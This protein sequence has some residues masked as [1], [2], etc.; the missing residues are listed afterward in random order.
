MKSVKK[1]L[2]VLLAVA[3]LAGIFP[4]GVM[5]V[6]ETDPAPVP[7]ITE[8]GAYIGDD[9]VMAVPVEQG[10]EDNAE[11]MSL[12]PL[13][14]RRYDLN[15]TG[16]LEEEL[17]NAS[18]QTLIA[19]LTPGYDPEQTAETDPSKYVVWAKWYYY[20]EDGNWV[21]PNDDYKLLGETVDLSSG[22]QNRD[23]YTIELI[24]G[25]CDQLNPDNVR[26]QVDVY[27]GGMDEMLS[28][29]ATTLDGKAITIYEDETYYQD[30][31]YS[32]DN[33]AYYQV[34]AK[35][36]GYPQGQIKVS[37]GFKSAA[38]EARGFDVAVYEG[39]YQTAE[40][41]PAEGSAKNVTEKIWM[42][43]TTDAEGYQ[44][45][46]SYRNMP[47]FT[48]VLTG[49]DNIKYVLP[50]GV[51]VYPDG[52][53]V[54]CNDLYKK[55]TT[56]SYDYVEWN[57]VYNYENSVE[58]NDITLRAGNSLTGTYYVRLYVNDP[59]GSYDDQIASVQAVYVGKLTQAQVD[60]KTPGGE[61]DVKAYLIRSKNYS[62]DGY[63]QGYLDGGYAVD[64]SQY[65]SGTVFTILDR[66]GEIHYVG[67]RLVGVRPSV[68]VTEQVQ[69]PLSDDIYFRMLGPNDENIRSYTMPYENDSYYYNGYQTVFLLNNGGPVT[70]E[71]IT[72]TFFEG[73]GVNMFSNGTPGNTS[74]AGAAQVSGE[75]QVNFLS[76]QGIRY[77]ATAENK[78]EL[79]NYWVTFVTQQE[80]PTLYVNGTN[81]VANYQEDPSNPGE[82]NKIPA[83]VIYLTETYDYHH[84]IFF[85]NL[86]AETLD[87]L[88]VTLTGPDGTGEAVGVE[89]DPYWT[90][91]ATK[92]LAGFTT[93]SNLA[94][95]GKIRLQPKQD[96]TT[97]EVIASRID[98]LLIIGAGSGE[99]R[100]EVK[101]RLVGVAGE[102][103]ITT[104]KL[105]D[106]IKHVS[107]SSLLQTNYMTSGNASITFKLTSGQLPRGLS[108]LQNGEIYGIPTT[109]GTYT[110]TISATCEETILGRKN[111]WTDSATYTVEITDSKDSA[112]V[113][114]YEASIFGDEAYKILI[115]IPN[116]ENEDNIGE[117]ATK[118]ENSWEN[119]TMILH[120]DGDY[121][122]FIDKVF[123]DGRQL[124]PG[125]DYTSE[126]GS[127][128][129]VIKTQT[130]TNTT[131]GTHTLS[132]ESRVGDKETGTLHRA[133]QTYDLTTKG[134][135]P[136][137]HSS[138]SSSTVRS[139]AIAASPTT[140]GAVK[141]SSDKTSAGTQVTITV[142]PDAGYSLDTIKATDANGVAIALTEGEGGIYTF[143]MPSSAVTVTATFKPQ[144]QV[145]DKTDSRH[146]LDV[147]AEAWYAPAVDY[148]AQVGLMTGVSERIFQPEAQT[149]RA[150]L[151]TILYRMDGSPEQE[152]VAFADVEAGMW[153]TA[154]MVW[155]KE[156]GVLTGYGDG[157]FGPTDTLTR[158]QVA[159]ILYHYAQLKEYDTS[160]QGDLS[161]YLDA[162]E[163]S[164][165]ALEALSWA[166]ANELIVGG[167]NDTL[168]PKEPASRAQIAQILKNFQA[169]ATPL[170]KEN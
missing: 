25:T 135:A 30:G 4:L 82:E 111:T 92:T 138:G 120:S 97:G 148:V 1:S 158:E 127:T 49:A 31:T 155:A 38:W 104:E 161:R 85:A 67:V 160:A 37:F 101:I 23:S 16:Y 29:Q 130:L 156:T 152:D 166:N 19:G 42:S 36:Q 41:L 110:F 143:T 147:S 103:K 62:S 15:L 6:E 109:P 163:V 7:E 116:E 84:D 99:N 51:Y 40:Q 141:L 5:A 112:A 106:G 33:H 140:N 72:P 74:T 124:T 167:G 118:G 54:Y 71:K 123:L 94:N 114:N 32:E 45:E 136:S 27:T 86:G 24:V 2:A 18:L 88:S 115:A 68:P 56:G 146:F 70:A 129:L 79:K 132:V 12:L 96:A 34:G 151:A 28:F 113:W 14:T 87:G 93:T 26:Y 170:N 61:D 20:D 50:F 11:L 80:K 46:Y 47:E 57:S 64:F 100:Q 139:Y 69:D 44:A 39:Y 21:N 78:K 159:V 145:P 52:I 134:R 122:T 8:I 65:R 3:L 169:I 75:T 131:R 154:A 66:E 149:N 35:A 60:A 108:L 63:E 48:L 144:E 125:V 89:L 107:Y 95:I 17:K 164:N 43:G 142:T 165:F 91:G 162:A 168:D 128:R 10:E 157:S 73:D 77:T 105:W 58:Y 53:N 126:E 13:E 98:G 153:Y 119:E 55:A 137:S 133:A 81:D 90:I 83:R 102:F 117:G 150:M 121:S 76:G 59:E 22:A 9:Y